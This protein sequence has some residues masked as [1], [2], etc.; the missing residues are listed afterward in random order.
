[1]TGHRVRIPFYK[2]KDGKLSKSQAHINI[3]KRLLLKAS[4]RV[5]VLRKGSP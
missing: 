2:I 3:S 4:K 1:M 5:R